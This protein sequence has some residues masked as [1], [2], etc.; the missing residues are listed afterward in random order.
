MTQFEV[1]AR[2]PRTGARAGILHTAHGPIETPAFMPVGTQATVK[3]LLPA[4]LATIGP[5]CVLANA[6]HLALRPGA[7]LVEKMGGIHRFMGWPGPMLTDSGGFQVFSLA[8][9]REVDDAGVTFRSHLNGRRRRFTPRS[10]VKIEEQIGADVIMPLDECIGY[11]S[12]RAEAER[13]LERSHRWALQSA[14][15]H[16]RPDQLLFAIVQGGMEPDLR[17]QAA[18]A[19]AAERF[20]GYAIGGLSVGEPRALTDELV[21]LLGRRLPDD[22]PRYLM[23]VGEPDQLVTY[24]ALG[25]DMFDC[26]SPTRHGRTGYAYTSEGRVNIARAS[27]RA[28]AGPVD[29]A[30]DCATCQCYSRAYLHHLFRTGEPLGPRLLSLHNVAYLVGVLEVARA[31]IIAGMFGSRPDVRAG[32]NQSHGETR[33]GNAVGLTESEEAARLCDGRVAQ[34]LEVG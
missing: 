32:L 11:P 19:L 5:R 21:G 24:A 8:D 16:T 31:Q 33:R 9:R 17:A 1:V 20:P 2:C 25:I 27:Q 26:V 10:V 34:D 14:R 15:A 4:D 13:T 23:G 29:P 3:G 28:E 6:Y 7:S 18:D 30:C 12:T 22:R